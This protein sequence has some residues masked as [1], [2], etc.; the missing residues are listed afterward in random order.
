MDTI[1]LAV[2]L[3][4]PHILKKFKLY[5]FS[6]NPR[7]E[8]RKKKKK[9]KKR[10]NT[11]KYGINLKE[12]LGSFLNAAKELTCFPRPLII[13]STSRL[14][15]GQ[16]DR[17]IRIAKLSLSGKQCSIIEENLKKMKITSF[18]SLILGITLEQS[19]RQ[20]PE[21]GRSNLPLFVWSSF[22]WLLTCYISAFWWLLTW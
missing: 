17:W 5:I 2:R 7:S 19:G 21:T 8:V 10:G 6:T 3:L 20:D 14:E 15:N 1:K 16:V 9:N 12:R 4:C 18:A 11:K 22:R 13:L